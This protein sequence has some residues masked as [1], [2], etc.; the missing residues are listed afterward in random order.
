[1]PSNFWMIANNERNFRITQERGFSVMGLKSQHR[2]KVQRISEDDRI[3]L[4]VTHIRR[5][6][7]TVTATSDSL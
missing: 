4:Y 1:M 6:V 7:A 5:F 3:L 2:R